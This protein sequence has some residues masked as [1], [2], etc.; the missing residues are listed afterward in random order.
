MGNRPPGTIGFEPPPPNVFGVGIAPSRSS[1][2][3]HGADGG[4]AGLHGGGNQAAAQVT[5][6]PRNL[7]WS[8]FPEVDSAPDGSD[9]NAQIH[10]EI[11]QPSNVSVVNEHG[12]VRV[13]AL[14]VNLSVARSDCWVVRSAKADDLL[15][16]EQGHFDITGMM[17]RDLGAEIMAARASSTADLQTAVTAIIQRY[18]TLATS[19]NDRY[20]VET[21]H[22]RNRDAQ[23]RWDARI[24]SSMQ[25]GARFT[26]P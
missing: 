10:A 3:A 17:G 19:L 9:E 20:D 4:R 12:Q 8:D 16:H 13:S 24:R 6:W 18:R 2:S 7:T 21:N 5:G 23:A 22:G 25:S 26:P 14:T 15:S 11:T 1:L